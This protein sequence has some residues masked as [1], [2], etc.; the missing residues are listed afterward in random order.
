MN[1]IGLEN[2]NF[3][4]QAG[5]NMGSTITLLREEVTID[6][7]RIDFYEAMLDAIVAKVFQLLGPE[8]DKKAFLEEVEKG[9]L[10]SNIG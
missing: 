4:L 1:R 3:Y 9:R 5:E 10:P 7:D 8:F 2:A 6:A